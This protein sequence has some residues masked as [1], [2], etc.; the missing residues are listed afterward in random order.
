[1]CVV[2]TKPIP[3]VPGRAGGIPWRI[4]ALS[5]MPALLV[6]THL[7]GEQQP[8]AGPSA[9]L[10]SS[11]AAVINKYC[12]SCHDSEVKKGGL[13]LERLSQADVT[14]HSDEWEK[15]IRKLR[16]RQMPPAGKD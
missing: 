15:V 10:A 2:V 5:C 11:A 13:D 1:M 16:A 6:Q 3:I 4:L 14:R 12:F 9:R 8:P 7:F